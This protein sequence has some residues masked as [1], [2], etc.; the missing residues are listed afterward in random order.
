MAAMF[1]FVGGAGAQDARCPDLRQQLEAIDA[2]GQ[3]DETR[4][5]RYR[6]AIERQTYELERT[7]DYAQSIGC[8][9][10]SGGQC[11][12]LAANLARM[13][14]NLATLRTQ[15]A[16]IAANHGELREGERDRILAMLD[17]LGCNG[18]PAQ[19]RSPR[20]AGLF[21]ELFGPDES[22]YPPP[23]SA[24]PRGETPS[25]EA[26]PVGAS[27]RT[28]CVRK[29]DG[30]YF[31]ISFS[32][33]SENFE[34]DE[35]ACRK[36]CPAAQ[37][38]LY[39]YDTFT[40]R[41]DDAVS[42]RSGEP[43]KS[44]PNAFKFRTRYDQSC[45]CRKAGEAPAQSQAAAEDSLKRLDDAALDAGAAGAADKGKPQVEA[46]GAPDKGGADKATSAPT[47]LPTTAGTTVETTDRSGGKKKVR[48]IGPTFAPPP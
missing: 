43:L 7:A 29:C 6:D 37:V 15:Y 10:G 16:R 17:D 3:T 21:E 35:E 14:R 26:R 5:A 25:D 24:E 45:A 18:A 38:E 9:I 11:Q 44:M 33:S 39:A 4:V 20:S 34:A 23:P 30:Y 19:P 12:A 1:A 8:D 13:Q 36:Q 40:Q 46:G 31:P 2:S 48:I 32:T 47:S 22:L 27:L 42:T 28:I 41:A